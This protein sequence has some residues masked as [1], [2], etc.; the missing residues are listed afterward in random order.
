[1]PGLRFYSP[2]LPVEQ[3][4]IIAKELTEAVAR[5]LNLQES[6]RN[7]TIVQFMPFKLENVALGGRLMNLDAANPFYYLEILDSG[8]N[9]E[10]KETLV[11]ELTP[12]LAKLL[13]LEP[14]QLYKLSI[15]FQEYNPEDMARAGRFLSE[16]GTPV[17]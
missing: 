15:L 4:S 8:W 16:M 5:S 14:A 2:E 3:K 12:L 11:R 1:M 7:W 6:G 17:S 10:K 13:N 9:R